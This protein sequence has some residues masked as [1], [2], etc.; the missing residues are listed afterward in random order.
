MGICNTGCGNID[1]DGITKVA[2]KPETLYGREVEYSEFDK[3][4]AYI[5]RIRKSEKGKPSKNKLIHML[6]TLFFRI[7]PREGPA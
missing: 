2:F 5:I 4:E 7:C 3:Q 1:D 6:E